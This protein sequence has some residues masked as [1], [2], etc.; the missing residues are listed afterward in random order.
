MLLFQKAYKNW[1]ENYRHYRIKYCNHSLSIKN[2][3][4][5]PY[6][7]SLNELVKAINELN[8]IYPEGNLYDCQISEKTNPIILGNTSLGT[9]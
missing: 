5:D 3:D 8:T 9:I 2:G 6:K 1:I 7:K 4:E